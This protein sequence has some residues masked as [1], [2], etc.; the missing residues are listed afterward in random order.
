MSVLPDRLSDRYIVARR[1]N[2]YLIKVLVYRELGDCRSPFEW[3]WRSRLTVREDE[4]HRKEISADYGSGFS[5]DRWNKAD[6]VSCSSQ[7]GWVNVPGM[8]AGMPVSE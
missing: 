8:S 4:K 2:G 3:S 1:K 5:R 6:G 7:D